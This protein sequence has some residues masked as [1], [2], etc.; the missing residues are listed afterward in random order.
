MAQVLDPGGNPVAIGSG[1]VLRTPGLQGVAE[2]YLPSSPEMRGVDHS[3]GP[4][5]DALS[6][7]GISEELTVEIT[8]QSELDDAG[9]SRAAGGPGDIDLEVPNP[10]EGWAQVVLYTAEDGTASW[11]FPEG[12]PAA[13]SSTEAAVAAGARA[14]ATL[15]Y[16]IPR[17]VT[18]ITDESGQRGLFGV[19]GKKLIKVLSFA[20]DPLIKLA[21]GAI[22]R[23]VEEHKHLDGIRTFAVGEYQ[24]AGQ[25][26]TPQQWAAL[27]S[28]RALLFIH[29]TLSRSQLAFRS[30]RPAVMQ[31]LSDVYGG[32]LFAFDHCTVSK[33]PVENARWFLDNVPPGVRLDVD[34][35]THSRGGLVV[36][37]LDRLAGASA[38][39]LVINRAV[40]VAPPNDGTALVDVKHLRQF[41]NRYTSFL[42]LLPDN[43][44]T[45]IINVVL[46]VVQQVALAA[47]D[48]MEGLMSMNPQ[49]PSLQAFNR[50]QPG[51]ASYFAVGSNYEPPA[52]SAWAAIARDGLTDAV[53][54]H[55]PNDLVV[56]TD[57]TYR[58]DQAPGFPIAD[59]LVF[60]PEFAVGHSGYWPQPAF[61]QKL[62]QWLAVPQ[63]W[64]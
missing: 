62:Q 39:Q 64:T 37:A 26:P 24:V 55:I 59:P 63:P 40:M 9:G 13:P 60:G 27:S 47:Y 31:R 46:S 44:A 7:Q 49:E 57:G 19:L 22:A 18:V 11:H 58:V 10:G 34:V 30:I 53:F 51:A 54:G 28:G 1:V 25:P 20:I 23:Y 15:H 6:W 5:L 29:G 8:G 41:L 56:P 16:S 3:T 38:G 42:Q 61:E 33:T 36:R 43:A 21:A 2:V 48:G 35:I 14:G 52:G 50:D 32:R 12:A 4:F 45:D 17:A